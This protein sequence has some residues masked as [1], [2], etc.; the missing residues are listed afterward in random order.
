[1]YTLFGYARS[2]SAAIECALQLVGEP[3]QVVNAATWA[4]DSALAQLA[5]ANPLQ[6]IPT[7]V[8]PDGS[9][10]TESA[11]ILIHLGLTYPSSGLL[12][13]QES[14]RTQALR[15][16][17]YIPANCYSL[18]SVLDYPERY[19]ANPS[20]DAKQNLLQGARARMY[21]HWRIFADLF[22]PRPYLCGEN[23]C[24]LDILVAVV[25]HWS[26][27]RDY[28]QKSHKAFFELIEQLD[29]TEPL[30][31]VFASHWRD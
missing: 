14:A 22:P 11:A 23:L 21:E 28:L 5:E 8:L 2:G 20:E 3:Y 16:L 19:L 24:A 31:S 29:V 12:P 27:T 7:L 30:E 25:S 1:M 6:Q 15:G 13:A 26:G 10:M 17:V 9:V 18:I 4:E